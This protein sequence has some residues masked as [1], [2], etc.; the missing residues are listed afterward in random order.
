M[1][2]VDIVI[3]SYRPRFFEQALRSALG[4]TYPNTSVFI[5]DNC[6]SD[7]IEKISKKY[8]ASGVTYMRSNSLGSAN[9]LA[10]CGM[11]SGDIVKPLND[12]DIL[13]PFCVERMVQT[14]GEHM[15]SS[16]VGTVF[17]ASTVIDTSN[18]LTGNRAPFQSTGLVPKRLVHT[19]SLGRATNFYG[20]LSSV[21]FSR[22]HFADILALGGMKWRDADCSN[23][24]SDFGMFL[25]SVERCPS[26]YVSEVLSY[27]RRSSDHASDSN[28]DTNPLFFKLHLKWFEL[29]RC[30][31]FKTEVDVFHYSRLKAFVN[32]TLA[33]FPNNSEVSE[34]C[35][36][37]DN[38]LSERL[39]ELRSISFKID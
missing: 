21:A 39:S 5:S 24:N 31:D 10:A 3:P 11:G 30:L 33:A 38:F 34:A 32:N 36:N 4:Q 9:Y 8:E 19:E 20:E 22:R 17:S 35:T 7:E 16:K 25:N 18:R 23:G 1:Y 29:L 37:F 26:G 15:H 14:F 12:D 6:P 2:K 27:F 13:H 28:R